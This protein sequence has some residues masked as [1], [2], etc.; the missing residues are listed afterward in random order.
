MSSESLSTEKW[1]FDDCTVPDTG[2]S[3]YEALYR[4]RMAWT[5][6]DQPVPR[7]A[8]AVCLIPPSGL[9]TIV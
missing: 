1:G 3:V 5:F 2:V 9:R 8:P 4:R 7:D 6:K